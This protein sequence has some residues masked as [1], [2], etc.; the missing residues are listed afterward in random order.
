MTN[1]LFQDLSFQLEGFDD[2]TIPVACWWPSNTASSTPPAAAAAA[3][4]VYSHRISIQRIGQLLAQWNFIPSFASRNFALQPTLQPHRVFQGQLRDGWRGPV[5][6]LA[7]GYLGSR[8]D[9]SHLAEVLAAAGFLC[10]APEYP[11]S[12]AASYARL[13]GLDR[14]AIN[15]QL[16]STALPGAWN[17]VGTRFGIVGHS[18]GTATA[19][20]TG[21][22][23]WAR[24][25][26]AGFPRQR[27]GSAIGGNL[28]LICSL[29]D[30]AVSLNRFGGRAAI[31][32]DYELLVVNNDDTNDN[33]NRDDASLLPRRAAWILD[34]PNAPNHIS[35]LSASVNDAMID[36]LSPLLPVAQWAN[37]PVL[38]FDKYQVSRDAGPTAQL[39]HPVILRY[40][41]QEMNV[42]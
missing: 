34:A 33:N 13:P 26:L 29:N 23:S 14:A 36:L 19:L 42:A 31:P 12:L 8:F 30:G 24:V 21:D 17:I 35:F 27:D 38:D 20:T 39:L 22:E 9:L 5:V 16:L 6:V 15:Q 32:A 2:T 10:V 3:A 25:C 28:L 40:L 4:A 11:E 37:I 1:V 18:L 41:R 7:H